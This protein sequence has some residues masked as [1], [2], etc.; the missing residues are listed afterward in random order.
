MAVVA[1]SSFYDEVLPWAPGCNT[2]MADSAIRRAA[3][4]LFDKGLLWRKRLAAI[5]AVQD[6]AAYTISS[7]IT[8]VGIAQ[9]ISVRYSNK[10]LTRMGVSQ[11]DDYYGDT[12][13][14]RELK[15]TPEF[16]TESAPGVITLVPMP[17]VAATGAIEVEAALRPTE[18]STGIDTTDLDY[19]REYVRVIADGALAYIKAEPRKPWTDIR[20]AESRRQAF[21]EAIGA[22]SYLAAKGRGRNRNFRVK[23]HFD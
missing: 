18:A 11:L 13:D 1:W 3:I 8:N 9:I 2:A 14:W 4:E 19:W 17:S 10:T 20:G 23:T 7:G 5:N 6:Q 12:V 16:Y 15:G 22:Y 21:V